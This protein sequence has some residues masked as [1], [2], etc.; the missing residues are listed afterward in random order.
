MQ[1]FFSIFKHIGFNNVVHTRFRM[2]CT[3]ICFGFLISFNTIAE[4]SSATPTD[5]M[6]DSVCVYLN[7]NIATVFD[8]EF[9]R[10]IDRQNNFVEFFSPISFDG[11]VVTY[12][13]SD[14]EANYSE[15]FSVASENQDDLFKHL[16]YFIAWFVFGFI[17]G[18]GWPMRG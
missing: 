15:K 11:K 16:F 6:F 2:I 3:Q 8:L 14:K 4:A 13:S 18:Y 5:V 9:Q 7:R 12:Q 1:K 10:C 17:C